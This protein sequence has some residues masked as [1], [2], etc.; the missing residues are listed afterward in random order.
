VTGLI[1]G[2]PQ[3]A[4]DYGKLAGDSHHRMSELSKLIRGSS[5]NGEGRSRAD[6]YLRG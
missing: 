4:S 2:D 3:E 1:D 5:S 6:E